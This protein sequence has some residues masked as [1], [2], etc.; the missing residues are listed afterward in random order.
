MSSEVLIRSGCFLFVLAVMAGWELLAPRRL[1]TVAKTGRWGINLGIVAIDTALLQLLP[2]LP[3]GM[4]LLAEARGWGVLTNYP[5]P[6]GVAVLVSVAVLDFTIYLQHVMFHFVPLFWRFHRMHHT[7]LDFD[8]STGVRFHPIEIVLS[9]CIKLAVVAVIGPPALAV[10]LFE[11]LLN[12]TSLFS[13]GNI[14]IHPGLDRW[15]RWLVVTP[16]MHRVH[17]SVL[18]A[19][20]NSNFGFNIPWWDRLCGTYRPQPAAGHEGMTI[21]LSQFREARL[22]TLPK[23]LLLPFRWNYNGTEERGRP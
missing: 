10:L 12:A 17:H 11:V 20:T 19:E 2:V 21:G 6:P 9:S 8:T 1:L 18:P 5:L 23:L 16:D 13:H 22:L 7:D 4:A 3:V 15:L 14:R